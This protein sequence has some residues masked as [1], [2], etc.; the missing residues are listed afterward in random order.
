MNVEI[1]HTHRTHCFLHLMKRVRS[2]KINLS[3]AAAQSLQ[4]TISRMEAVFVAPGQSRY[5]LAVRHHGRWLIVTYDARL[6]C[7]VTVWPDQKR[8]R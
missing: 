8:V 6:H 1:L 5:R 3:S 2:R 4:D 7:L